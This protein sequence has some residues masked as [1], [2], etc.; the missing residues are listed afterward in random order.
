MSTASGPGLARDTAGNVAVT[1]AGQAAPGGI[2]LQQIG[3]AAVNAALAQL[4]INLQ[5]LGGGAMAIN[6]AAG[7][8]NAPASYNPG[9]PVAAVL[10]GFD[11]AN[12]QRL[13][14]ASAAVLAGQSGLGA[15]L[16]APPGQWA[17]SSAPAAGSQATATRAAGGAG[18]R[19]IAAALDYGYGATAA[20]AA[21]AQRLLNLRD[22]ASG[23]GAVLNQLGIPVPAATIPAVNNT[24]EGRAYP[25]SAATAMTAEFDAA[26][27]NLFESVAVSGYDAS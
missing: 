14:L 25:G 15:A 3:A 19:H 2:N 27:A 22:G 20:L 21:A 13:R 17:V 10:E 16:V 5:Q 11:G 24:V 9:L 1:M 26:T 6:L 7:D 4:G 12:M 8:G 23:L 18:V